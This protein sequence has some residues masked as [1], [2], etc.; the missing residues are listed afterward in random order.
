M[1]SAGV[2]MYRIASAER[3]VFS[4]EFEFEFASEDVDPFLVFMSANLM[5]PI[6]IGDVELHHP[7]AAVADQA[8]QCRVWAIVGLLEVRR[9]VRAHD[10]ALCCGVLPDQFA[11]SDLIYRCQLT[12]DADRRLPLTAFEA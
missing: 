11:D 3:D 10:L 9:C 8:G 2:E 1:W 6:V 5:S 4:A 7:E 12:K